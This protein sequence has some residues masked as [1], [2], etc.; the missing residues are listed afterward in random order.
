VLNDVYLA[1]PVQDIVV[2]GNVFGK[3]YSTNPCI[4]LSTTTNQTGV[5]AWDYRRDTFT[6]CAAASATACHAAVTGT[7]SPIDVTNGRQRQAEVSQMYQDFMQGSPG[8]MKRADE[9]Y[10]KE[11]LRYQEATAQYQ[12]Q[13]VQCR[14]L[15][16]DGLVERPACRGQQDDPRILTHQRFH[17]FKERF[18]L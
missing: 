6:A 16:G 17:S 9:Q 13:M 14:Q 3:P 2:R 15:A 5:D 1:A 18:G 8:A 12:Q 11:M 10:Q 4:Y 7:G